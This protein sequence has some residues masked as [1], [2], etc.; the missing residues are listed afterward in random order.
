[1]IRI[2]YIDDASVNISI[3]IAHVN[4]YNDC[5]DSRY[6]IVLDSFDDP[7]DFLARLKAGR[8]YDLALIDIDMPIMGGF[9][10]AKEAFKTKDIV[11]IMLSGMIDDADDSEAML[12]KE[13][14][15]ISEVMNRYN[16]LKLD[17]SRNMLHIFM[18]SVGF[19]NR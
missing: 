14:F 17:S 2:A 4:K 19:G 12:S 7:R 15:R 1:M 6:Q 18:R 9:D 3:V 10:V 16:S 5:A 11:I 8:H 13:K